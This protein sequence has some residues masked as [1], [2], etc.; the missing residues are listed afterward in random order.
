M[1]DILQ[2]TPPQG[3]SKTVKEGAVVYT[4]INKAANAFCVLTIYK[5]ANSSNN[6][7]TD[8]ANDW[9]TFVAKPFKAEE[10]PQTDS[11]TADG[12]T[13]ISATAPIESDGIKSLAIMT[14]FSGYGMTAVSQLVE[15]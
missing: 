15:L 9:K 11:Q 10:N 14:T 3:W 8:F 12:W 7:S 1:F 5:G 2:Y 13:V 4:D 6:A